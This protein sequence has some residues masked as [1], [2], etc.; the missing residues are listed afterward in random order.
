MIFEGAI[1]AHVHLWDAARNDDILILQ[2]H[3]WLAPRGEATKLADHLT[4][5]GVSGAIVVQSAPDAEHSDWL[6]ARA[7]EVPGVQGVVAWIDPF[8][9]DAQAHIEVLRNNPMVCGIRL[10]VNRY[11]RPEQFQ[12]PDAVSVLSLVAE[13]DLAI[14][15]LCPAPHLSVVKA[16][17]EALA[18]ASVILDHCGLP[19]ESESALA[20]WEGA[21]SDLA[22]LPNV[23]SKFSGLIEPFGP[24]STLSQ[25]E[26][27]AFK[28]LDIFGPERLML[29][30]NFPVADLGGGIAKWADM[31]EKLMHLSGLST[32]ERAAM[33]TETALSAYSIDPQR[34]Q[35]GQNA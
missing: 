18:H 17:A 2:D 5:T 30:S 35:E 16:I 13:A 8:A 6:R 19:P 32:N 1:D 29:S 22:T 34:S 14:E 21:L 28:T 12:T 23:T 31:A 24:D 3:P 33:L 9:S 15:C 7:S 27:R 11:H 10:M 25:I 4:A 20:D 26:S